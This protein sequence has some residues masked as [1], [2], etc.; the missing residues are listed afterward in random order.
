MVLTVCLSSKAKQFLGFIPPIEMEDK[1][2]YFYVS[3]VYYCL[4]TGAGIDSNLK[5]IAFNQ[6]VAKPIFVGE[7]WG[8]QALEIMKNLA[9]GVARSPKLKDGLKPK[10]GTPESKDII[11][12]AAYHEAGHVRIAIEKGISLRK[13][14][15]CVDDKGRGYSDMLLYPYDPTPNKKPSC[16]DSIVVLY[17]GKAAEQYFFPNASSRSDSEDLRRIDELKPYLSPETRLADLESESLS[18]VNQYRDAIEKLAK[19]LLSKGSHDL[20]TC[21]EACQLKEYYDGKTAQRLCADEIKKLFP[22]AT[23]DPVR[24]QLAD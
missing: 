20:K 9:N 10:S 8:F 21:E 6:S 24:I 3:G 5:A 17:G 4:T 23:I 16:E 18:L 1:K 14:G 19:T 2:Y 15:M 11:K 13:L 7:E 22:S 12:A